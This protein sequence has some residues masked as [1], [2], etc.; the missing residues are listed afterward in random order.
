[1]RLIQSEALLASAGL[2]I[3]PGGEVR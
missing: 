1:M 3:P 2:C